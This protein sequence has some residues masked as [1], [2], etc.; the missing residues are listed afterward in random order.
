MPLRFIIAIL[1]LMTPYLLFLSSI[2]PAYVYNLAAQA[3]VPIHLL[4]PGTIHLI[5]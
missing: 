3:G 5:I 4:I 2:S 1:D